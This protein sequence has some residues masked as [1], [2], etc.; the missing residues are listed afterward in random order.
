MVYFTRTVSLL[1]LT[2]LLPTL[3]GSSFGNRFLGSGHLNQYHP[4]HFKLVPKLVFI[5]LV[6]WEFD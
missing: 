2:L 1:P 4:T 5:V 6:R 3:H